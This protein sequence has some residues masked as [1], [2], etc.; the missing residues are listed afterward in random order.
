MFKGTY[1]HRIDAKGR[2]PVPAAFRRSLG[3]DRQVV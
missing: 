3:E 2:L 1:H